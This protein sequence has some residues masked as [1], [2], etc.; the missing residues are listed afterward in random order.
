MLR[1]TTTV[2][3]FFTYIVLP[4]NKDGTFAT[5]ISCSV[6]R[7]KSPCK[8]DVYIVTEPHNPSKYYFTMKDGQCLE[9]ST[10]LMPTEMD[11]PDQHDEQSSMSIGSSDVG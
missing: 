1:I 3:G 8:D 2:G 9:G 10:S 4:I 7:C 5:P 11:V 6:I